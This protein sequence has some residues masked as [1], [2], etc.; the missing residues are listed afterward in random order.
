MADSTFAIR[1]IGI[2]GAA[3]VALVLALTFG[4]LA[5]VWLRAED[6]GRLGPSE[7]AAL[8]FTLW[9]AA[10]SALISVGLAIPVARALARRQFPGRGLVITL[11]GAP[12][13]LP[14]IVAVFGLLAIFGRDGLVSW[15]L[16]FFGLPPVSIYGATGVILA[17]V[18]F[19][20]PLAVRFILMGWLAIPAERFR[21]AAQLQ[22]DRRAYWRVIELPMLRA[23]VPGVALVIFLLCL[24]SFA[25]A[26]AVGGGPKATTIELAIYQAFL[27]EFDLDKAARLACLQ[28]LI[29][30]VAALLSIYVTTP[31]DLSGG[32]D[33]T[34]QRWD[35]RSVIYDWVII[36]SAVALLLLPLSAIVM[37]G[38]VELVGLPASVWR[39]A[40][41]SIQIS[42][43]ATVLSVALSL[44]LAL[45][46]SG[47]SAGF[48][49]FLSAM[50]LAASPLVMGTG[51][52][53][54]LF[55]FTSPQDW[56]FVV[57]ACVNAIVVLPFAF[58]VLAPAVADAER[59]F[60]R[61]GDQLG[62]RGWA[63]FRIV[64]GPRLR[65]PLGFTAGLAAALSMGDLGVVALFA[66]ASTATLPLEMYRLMGA[67]RTDDAAGAALLLILL[68]FA[69]FWMFDR[70]GRAN[71][72]V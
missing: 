7:W 33:R 25:V 28:F 62:L 12:F 72:A 59:Q 26:L 55:P 49:Q 16:S 11:L 38:V 40:L 68:S 8:R 63:R 35:T 36:L 34:V 15:F 69:A 10:L 5:A 23:V 32:L 51:L 65:R 2:A 17:H 52:F 18:F 44:T 39:A 60:G 22:F 21:L 24:T 53:L 45:W 61:I 3:A 13:L 48:G 42:A 43:G 9:Q 1:P 64:V 27:F 41:V 19:N 30:G 50:V 71:A 46:L 66:D 37:R 58:R 14:V 54:L 70:G 67:Y 4:T 20:L 47:R 6:V 56:A 31:S 29:C 57:T